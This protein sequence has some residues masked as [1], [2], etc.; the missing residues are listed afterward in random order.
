MSSRPVVAI[1]SRCLANEAFFV[2][3]VCGVF[4]FISATIEIV[5]IEAS[6]SNHLQLCNNA[7][8]LPIRFSDNGTVGRRAFG[9]R[10]DT[11]LS[12]RDCLY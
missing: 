9:N 12:V 3:M 11:N 10:L 2:M 1:A 4:E 8:N 7:I 5:N 6:A